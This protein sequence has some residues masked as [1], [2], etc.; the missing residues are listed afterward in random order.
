MDETDPDGRLILTW[1]EEGTDLG[2]FK[3]PHALVVDAQNRIYVADRENRRIQLFDTT[4]LS[5]GAWTH[6]GYPYG[7]TLSDQ[8]VLWVTDA[9]AERILQLNLDGQILGAFGSPGSRIGEFGFVHSLA[10]TDAGELLTAEVRNWRVQQFVEP[11]R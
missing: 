7:L 4:G 1:G 6:V 10:V 2:Q 8:G 9:R 3:H 11:Q 5:L